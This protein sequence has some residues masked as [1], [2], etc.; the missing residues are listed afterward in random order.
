MAPNE[1]LK[2]FLAKRKPWKHGLYTL[3]YSHTIQGIKKYMC[4]FKLYQKHRPGW[5][6][7]QI[8]N[9]YIV[10]GVPYI[11]NKG[12]HHWVTY[13]ISLITS[14]V[15][16][17]SPDII[18]F[19]HSMTSSIHRAYS[20]ESL[21]FYCFIVWNGGCMVTDLAASDEKTQLVIIRTHTRVLDQVVWEESSLNCEGFTHP[22]HRYF[23]LLPSGKWCWSFQKTTFL[24][25]NQA[26]ELQ[27]PLQT[28]WQS[29]EHSSFNS[30]VLVTLYMYELVPQTSYSL[31]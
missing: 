16:S 4:V 25:T 7:N 27:N 9:L 22:S 18:P 11:P 24:P 8:I 13:L 21:F 5:T 15:I 2:V 14:I 10:L 3:K 19:W 20:S 17:P 12:N 26:S 30:S 23:V 6:E 28:H 31:I 1:A 29:A